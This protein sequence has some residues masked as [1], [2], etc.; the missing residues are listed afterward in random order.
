[1]GIRERVISGF[2]ARRQRILDGKINSIPSPLVRFREDFL[3]IEQKKYY[4]ITS[5]TKGKV[6]ISLNIFL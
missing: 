6:F 3:G 5:S 2:K 4:V 1:M